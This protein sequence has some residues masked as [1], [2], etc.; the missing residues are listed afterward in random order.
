MYVC[1]SKRQ[2]KKKKKIQDRRR[3]P[4]TCSG[5]GQNS[6]SFFF[7][8]N[9]SR[10]DFCDSSLN[11]TWSIRE[12]PDEGGQHLDGGRG[13]GVTVEPVLHLPAETTHDVLQGLVRQTHGVQVL[14]NLK[15][16]KP[17]SLSTVRTQL[18]WPVGGS[19]VHSYGF[20]IKSQTLTRWNIT[21]Q[22]TFL[23]NYLNVSSY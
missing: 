16:E 8:P 12:G 10:V 14:V 11:S 7:I 23:F 1:I 3:H 18:Q 20:N 9:S 21:S 17:Q 5:P 4:Y 15:T 6:L 2:E 22:L 19:R 13:V